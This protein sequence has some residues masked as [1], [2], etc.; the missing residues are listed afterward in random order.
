LDRIAIQI[1]REQKIPSATVMHNIHP[2]K[3]NIIPNSSV[4][5]G[6][7]HR[8]IIPMALAPV[9][10]TAIHGHDRKRPITQAKIN[11]A[12]KK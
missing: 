11:I 7:V 2:Q 1:T 12:G 4:G 9:K 5:F 3:V 8:R 6:H 10:Q